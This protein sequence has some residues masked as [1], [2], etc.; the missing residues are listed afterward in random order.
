MRFLI[1]EKVFE[2]VPWLSQCEDGFKQT[3]SNFVEREAFARD[4]KIQGVDEEGE[5]CV[6]AYLIRHCLSRGYDHL[7]PGNHGAICSS[8]QP[9]YETRG[10]QRRLDTV[11]W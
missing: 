9:C 10:S 7:P 4:E 1:S 2:C 8:R 11:R 3:L 5:R 6:Y